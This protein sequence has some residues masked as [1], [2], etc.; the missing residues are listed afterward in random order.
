M[1][2]YLNRRPVSGPWGGGNKVVINLFESLTSLGHQVVFRLEEGINVIFCFDPRPNDVHEWYQSFI[3]Y[4]SIHPN[5]KIVQRVGDVGTH[6]KPELLQ[7]VKQSVYHSDHIIFPSDWAKE[8][9]N[10]RKENYHVVKNGPL[11]TFHEYKNN[12]ELNETFKVITHHW[13]TNPKKGFKHY[14]L[15]DEYV[16][17]QEDIDFTFV[18]RLPENFRF[19]HAN[20]IEATGD[21]DY[22]AK[23]LSDQDLY[24]TASEEEAG[25]NHVLEALAA[26]IPIVYHNN[27][28]SI[29]DYCA[30]YGL[31]YDNFEEMITRIKDIKDNH[32][33]YKEKA[34][35]Y[36]YTIDDIIR[37]YVRII[38]NV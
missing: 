33:I 5:T 3:N 35:S 25:A 8:Y 38:E 1:K 22:L 27:G 21:N 13:S 17:T 18:G 20:Y 16:G 24:L 28:G 6:N 9:I 31:G 30:N 32:K 34:M 26:G 19:K 12:K 37:E 10:Y 15:L 4:K 2:I 11:K 23:L 14:R 7:L 29:L 36:T